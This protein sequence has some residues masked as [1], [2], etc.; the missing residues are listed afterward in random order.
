MTA[1][2]KTTTAKLIPGT[3]ILVT[4]IDAVDHDL[5][6][7]THVSAYRRTGSVIATVRVVGDGVRPPGGTQ[8][9]RKIT[10][11]VGT[12]YAYGHSVHFL[13]NDND[14]KRA[15]REA[16]KA[17]DRP[18][19]QADSATVLSGVTQP[20]FSDAADEAPALGFV[21]IASKAKPAVRHADGT[22]TRA[23]TGAQVSKAAAATFR[24]EGSVMLTDGRR[25]VIDEEAPA[26]GPITLTESGV[27]KLAA[28]TGETP[29]KIREA[30]HRQGFATEPGPEPTWA[31]FKGHGRPERVM[32]FGRRSAPGVGVLATVRQE[33]GRI[34]VTADD[35]AA[36]F[37]IAGKF[38]A[39]P[40][41]ADSTTPVA[42]FPKVTALGSPTWA[43]PADAVAN[44]R[45]L[46]D[47]TTGKVRVFWTLQ[48]RD[49]M[50][51]TTS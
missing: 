14:R 27:A 37:G 46:A 41:V 12:F 9:L 44:F 35:G 23:D 1:Q 11:D 29:D 48:A 17:A 30:A 33:R 36:F 15:N 25:V 49:A 51:R 19:A 28:H 39:S 4:P 42:D 40:M 16:R 22:V 32:Y 8:R 50:Q 20:R 21:T 5:P 18:Q 45:A 13:A 3:E 43:R 10:T 2:G 7:A 31:T 6:G 38:W 24:Q 47:A 34:V 26:L